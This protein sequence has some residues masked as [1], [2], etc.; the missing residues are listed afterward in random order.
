MGMPSLGAPYQQRLLRALESPDL[1]PVLHSQRQWLGMPLHRV[2]LI[3]APLQLQPQVPHLQMQSDAAQGCGE[4][5]PRGASV[6]VL[7]EP[8]LAGTR[9]PLVPAATTS[10][11]HLHLHLHLHLHRLLCS[12]HDKSHALSHSPL[13][14]RY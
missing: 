10:A 11:I 6:L 1:V 2:A 3:H 14:P 7:A 8:L 9:L 13:F 5:A 12:Q 4:M